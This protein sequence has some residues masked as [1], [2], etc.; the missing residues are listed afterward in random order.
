MTT[1]TRNW[2]IAIFILALPFVLFLGFLF[3]METEPLPPIAS[4]P[5]PNGY[6]DL[7]K[8]GKMVTA[9]VGDHD[10]IDEAQL[11]ELVATNAEALQ[12]LRAGLSNQCRVPAQQFSQT[13]M[14]NHLNELAGFKRLAQ[15][16]VAEGRLAE[17]ENRPG[18]AAKSYLDTIRLGNKSDCGGILID[19]LVS[20]AIEAMGV[21]H[22]QKLVDQLDA[23]SCREAAATLETLDAQGQSWQ[24]AVQQE[25]DWSRR[26]YPGVRYELV[27]LMSRNSLNKAFQKAEEKFNNQQMKTR[28]LTVALAARAYELDKGHRPVNIADLVPDYLKAIPQDPVTGS[29][30]VYSP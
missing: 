7:V 3:F 2:L 29:N 26:A 19:Q 28:Q 18:D 20:I 11:G 27:R 24:Q 21:A 1:K 22:L 13:N 8:A 25:R 5:N 30:L 17:M 12:L 14:E 6:D 23:K 15:A 9:D 4:L 16:F 10:K